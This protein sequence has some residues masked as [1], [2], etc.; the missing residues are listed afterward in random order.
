MKCPPSVKQHAWALLIEQKTGPTIVLTKL[1]STKS[2]FPKSHAFPLRAC[3][4]LSFPPRPHFCLENHSYPLKFISEA[5]SS[6]RM[7]P[8]WPAMTI[9]P[10]NPLPRILSCWKL[11]HH[12]RVWWSW[13]SLGVKDKCPI[14]KRRGKRSKGVIKGCRTLFLHDYKEI[15]KS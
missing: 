9:S 4:A 1:F 15:G 7:D 5:S 2:L 8:P 6:T 12:R 10:I 14:P 11:L 3:I 13:C